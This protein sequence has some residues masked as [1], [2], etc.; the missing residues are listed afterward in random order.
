MGKRPAAAPRAKPKSTRRAAR[1]PGMMSKAKTPDELEKELSPARRTVVRAL[2]AFVR[3]HAPELKEQMKW[4]GVAW[5]GKW[6]VCYCHANAG[7][8]HFGFF[9]GAELQDDSNI[10]EGTGK[11]IRHV[12]VLSPS[13]IREEEFARLLAQAIAIDRKA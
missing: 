10:L 4:G 3:K 8:V 1:K 7:D 12:K 2:R 5:V 9:R 11:F 13:N 6:N